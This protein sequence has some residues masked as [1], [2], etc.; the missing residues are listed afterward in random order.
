[1]TERQMINVLNNIL[2]NNNREDHIC[3]NMTNGLELLDFFDYFDEKIMF[4]NIQS[5]HLEQK[6][7]DLMMSRLGADFL[8]K[9]AL[10]HNMYIFDFGARKPTSRAIYQ[11]SRFLVYA[12]ERAWFNKIPTKFFIR[13][14]S[15]KATAI[16]VAKEFDYRYRQLSKS[17]LNYLKKFRTYAK[18]ARIMGDDR[19]NIIGLSAPTV[20]DGDSEYYVDVVRNFEE[21]CDFNKLINDSLDEWEV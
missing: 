14:R 8:M 16:N 9:A 20:H 18:N 21:K 4:V 13:P 19:V 12:L 11:G 6:R 2:E 15:D 7:Y 5:T 3:L 17:T 10:G 1:M